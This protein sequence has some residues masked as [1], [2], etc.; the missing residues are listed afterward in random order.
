MDQNHE[1]KATYIPRNTFTQYFTDAF[2]KNNQKSLYEAVCDAAIAT[3]KKIEDL[4]INDVLDKA[5]YATIVDLYSNRVMEKNDS[6]A[7]MVRKHIYN[8]L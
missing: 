1:Y 5:V 2:I 6:V 7:D 4:D 8:I 3:G